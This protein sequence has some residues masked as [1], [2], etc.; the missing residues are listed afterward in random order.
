MFHPG[1]D[2]AEP[3]FR[4]GSEPAETIGTRQN[5]TLKEQKRAIPGS[6]IG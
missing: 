5:R 3:V 1:S 6:L 2:Q 4:L